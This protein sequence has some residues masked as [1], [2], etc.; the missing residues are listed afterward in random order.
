MK[1][2]LLS[3]AMLASPV[4]AQTNSAGPFLACALHHTVDGMTVGPAG[5]VLG[6]G[7]L[8]LK[9]AGFVD[10][11]VSPAFSGARPDF[12]IA[13]MF[14]P[15]ATLPMGF[16]L[17]ALSSG[18]HTIFFEYNA[19]MQ[20]VLSVPMGAWGA[21]LFSIS[22][23]SQGTG[24]P[25][26]SAESLQPE[27][28]GGDVFSWVLPG[29]TLPTGL[30]PCV[31]IGLAQR[32]IDSTEMGL[33]FMPGMRPEVGDFDIF[34]PLYE[35]SGS[36][37]GMLDPDP[38][39]YFAL[40][41]NVAMDVSITSWF[42]MR[43]GVAL[44]SPDSDP[45]GATVLRVRWNHLTGMWSD[46]EVYVSWSELGLTVNDEIDALSVQQ[47]SDRVLLSLRSPMGTPPP[48]QLAQQLM[49]AAKTSPVGSWI[50]AQPYYYDD[51][52]DA[53]I[54][55][56][57]KV[58]VTGAEIDATS[59]PDPSGQGLAAAAFATIV[60]CRDYL[61]FPVPMSAAAT[62]TAPVAGGLTTVAIP[63]S[64]LPT[65]CGPTIWLFALGEA[66]PGGITS[67]TLAPLFFDFATGA[68]QT[69]RWSF[70]AQPAVYGLDVDFQIV[71]LDAC[72]L[73]FSDVPRGHF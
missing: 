17:N 24:D 27:G 60:D 3:F 12:T 50:A 46:P 51:G 57:Q 35:A 38:F 16:R 40:P 30:A 15:P 5:T 20:P 7:R 45:S 47:D 55:I 54:M 69:I 21:L 71:A 22:R 73:A 2:Y 31:P 62:V 14:G 11:D 33:Q 61:L 66:G 4:V 67:L 49:V 28:A 9:R 32:A 36:I 25:V 65:G 44:T 59:E 64:G 53:L 56:A 72:V 52:T 42:A 41:R 10:T 8:Y 34:L 43:N 26:V 29:S 19:S 23:T 37:V 18:Y 70:P 6:V 1:R 58:G 13:A 39:V 48:V 63:V 68:N